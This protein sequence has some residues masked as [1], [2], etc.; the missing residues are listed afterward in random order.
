MGAAV[1][2]IC[3][4]SPF[5]GVW[6]LSRFAGYTTYRG[7]ENSFW[8]VVQPENMFQ[9]RIHLAHHLKIITFVGRTLEK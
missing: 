5:N 6:H 3:P 2:I 8:I 9:N 7:F 1:N 4:S